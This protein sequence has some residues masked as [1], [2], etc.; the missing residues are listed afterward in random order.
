MKGHKLP[1]VTITRTNRRGTVDKRWYS[2]LIP[3]SGLVRH[4]RGGKVVK[5]LLDWGTGEPPAL[6]SPN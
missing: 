5:E 4:E 6:P 1:C 2:N 3:V